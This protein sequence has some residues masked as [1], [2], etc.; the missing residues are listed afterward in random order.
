MNYLIYVEHSAENLQFFLW[1]RDYVN[2]FNM[3]PSNEKQLAPEWTVAMQEE[4]R[5][6]LQKENT[7]K[8]RK[9]PHAAQIFQGTDF[10]KPGPEEHPVY[11]VKD[12]FSTPPMTPG[13]QASACATSKAT[14]YKTQASDAFAQAGARQP[15][16]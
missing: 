1:Y 8:M 10:G 4:T 2:R 3:A 5:A 13:D 15:C 7:E 12:P 14:S 16:K 9:E 6:R 11:G